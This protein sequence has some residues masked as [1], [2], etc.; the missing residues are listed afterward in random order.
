MTIL[1]R[2]GNIVFRTSNLDIGWDGYFNGKPM[3]S[4]VYPFK[5]VYTGRR[6]G[7]IVTETKAG[8]LL[9]LR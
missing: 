2:W 8:S 3:P 7:Q 4:G 1:D 6:N 9:L 5:S